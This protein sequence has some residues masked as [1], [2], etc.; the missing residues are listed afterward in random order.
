MKKYASIIIYLF[1]AVASVTCSKEPSDTT[2]GQGVTISNLE[3]LAD[4]NNVLRQKITFDTPFDTPCKIEYWKSE[5]DVRTSVVSP[6]GRHHTFRLLFLEPNTQYSFRVLSADGELRGKSVYNFT[7]QAI[8]PDIQDFVE[9]CVTQEY[10]FDGYILYS[11]KTSDYCMMI[12]S[13]LK[14]VWY[15]N[16]YPLPSSSARY[17][18]IT[19]EV[20]LMYGKAKEP[21]C[22]SEIAATDLYG[23]LVMHKSMSELPQPLLHHDIYQLAN[24]NW[25]FISF[26]DKEYDFNP[27]GADTICN[28]RGDGITVVDRN[29]DIEWQWSAFDCYSPLLDPE[30]LNPDGPFGSMS[31]CEDWLHANSIAEDKNGDIYVSFNRLEQFWKIDKESGEVIYRLGRNGDVE[32]SDEAIPSSMHSLSILEN[33]DVMFFENGTSERGYSRVLAFRVDETNKKAELV[34]NITLPPSLASFFQGSVYMIDDSHI[35]VHSSNKSNTAI[36][37]LDG[38]IVWQIHCGDVSFRAQYIPRIE[39]STLL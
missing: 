6:V 5:S 22:N 12:N 3:I 2:N 33:G 11:S 15:Y 4:K 28:V 27:I 1:V 26:I 10:D 39:E 14:P 19:Q 7:T 13:D 37:D 8:D 30:I 16:F 29:G 18:S 25:A 23:N 9:E 21:F 31:V 32:I 20:S 38:N 17:N 35:L 36:L 34:I 24:G